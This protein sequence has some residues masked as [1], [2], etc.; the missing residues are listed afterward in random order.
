MK[1]KIIPTTIFIIIIIALFFGYKANR[2]FLKRYPRV[3]ASMVT[4]N[5]LVDDLEVAGIVNSEE[6]RNLF[7]YSAAKI[8]TLLINEGDMVEAGQTLATLDS[9]AKQLELI[10]C[11]N[12]IVRLERELVQKELEGYTRAGLEIAEANLLAEKLRK[13]LLQKELRELTITAPISGKVSLLTLKAGEIANPGAK[14]AQIVNDTLLTIEA[15]TPAEDTPKI[16]PGDP[17]EIRVATISKPYSATV[18]QVLPPVKKPD[19]SF[20]NPR[21]KLRVQTG[22]NLVPGTSVKVR[23]LIGRANLAV[24]VPVEAIYEEIEEH[25]GDP[26]FFAV[27]P[28]TGQI[29]EYVYVLKDCSETL[30]LEQEREK[31]WLIRDN[32]YQARKVYVKTGVNSINRVEIIDGL[33]PFEQ[34]VIYA[35]RKIHD[36]D[37]VIVISRDESYKKPIKSGSGGW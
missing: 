17:A 16:K 3:Q 13:N 1:R 21:L 33:K 35:D 31:R 7:L 37:R 11:N 28:A 5:D 18:I 10:Q 36:Y 8:R 25:K 24:T 14:F 9:D 12:N 20:S 2:N 23:V 4:R 34:V 27:R 29:R 26:D 15:E 19:Q 32:I 30:G 6:V 22:V